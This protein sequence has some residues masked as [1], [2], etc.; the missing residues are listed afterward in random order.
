[1]SLACA[2][3]HKGSEEERSPWSPWRRA[4]PS[5]ANT[6]LASLLRCLLPD[7]LGATPA[8]VWA[9]A[10]APPCPAD[11]PRALAWLTGP[12]LVL[13]NMAA[14]AA[15]SSVV[16]VSGA[17]KTLPTSCRSHSRR[18]LGCFWKSS[19]GV[20][21]D[22]WPEHREEEEE[23]RVGRCNLRSEYS[24]V[25]LEQNWSSACWEGVIAWSEGVVA[26]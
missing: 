14:A 18:L 24:G 13:P 3:D 1:M 12:A 19:C 4:Y 17:K 15:A 8:P 6:A 9:A 16:R 25:E 26:R 10:A 22:G 23:T 11:P 5:P 21:K 7:S 2:D 20:G